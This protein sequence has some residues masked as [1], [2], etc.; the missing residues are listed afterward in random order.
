MKFNKKILITVLLLLSLIF[1][2]RIYAAA[3]SGATIEF[4]SNSSRNATYPDN[5]TDDKG[6]ITVLR[7]STI[8]QNDRWKAYVGNVSGRLTLDDANSYTIYDWSISGTVRGTVFAS[9]NST[10]VWTG[11]NCSDLTYTRQEETFL[12]HT[13]SSIDS[14]ENTFN[15][16]NH[17]PFY[18]GDRQVIGCNY[19]AL[20]VNDTAVVVNDSA[21]YQEILLWDGA[22][23]FVYAARINDSALGYRATDL[24]DFQMIVAEKAVVAAPVTYFFFVELQ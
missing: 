17:T 18:V 24:Y 11:I 13:F 8:Q 23:A 15:S 2:A 12:S 5:R 6:T 4:V 10:V 20:Y 7:L 14:I 9:R 22:G 3:P 1:A 21:S 19:T 16:V